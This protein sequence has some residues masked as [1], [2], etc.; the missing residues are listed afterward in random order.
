[1][2][3]EVWGVRECERICGVLGSG[4]RCV[5]ILGSGRGKVGVR[6]GRGSVGG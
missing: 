6:E 2:G 4:R 3:E 1:M 5:G